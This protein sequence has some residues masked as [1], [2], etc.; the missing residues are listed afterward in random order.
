[1]NA[2]K[3]EEGGELNVA[4]QYYRVTNLNLH[5]LTE[6][7]MQNLATNKTLTP[8]TLDKAVK[9]KAAVGKDLERVGIAINAPIIGPQPQPENE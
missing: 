7:S 2:K 3:A 9:V 1:V 8:E 5:T 6:T 4:H